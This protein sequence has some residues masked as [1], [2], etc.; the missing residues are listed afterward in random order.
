MLSRQLITHMETEIFW[1]LNTHHSKKINSRDIKDL[2]V[3]AKIYN[4]YKTIF[5]NSLMFL[6]IGDYLNEM[7]K[8]RNHKEKV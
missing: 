1:N 2:N 6:G 5:E 8:G 3:K 7:K 4:I